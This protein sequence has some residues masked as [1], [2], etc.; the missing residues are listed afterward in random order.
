MTKVFQQLKE[1]CNVMNK[2]YLLVSDEDHW[3]YQGNIFY[4]KMLIDNNFLDI[5]LRNID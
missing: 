2:N 1:K 3:S 4:G 5:M